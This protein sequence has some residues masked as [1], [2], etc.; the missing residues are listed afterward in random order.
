MNNI[1]Q[2]QNIDGVAI[3]G[4]AGQFPD[5]KNIDALWKNLIQSRESITFFTE[6]ELINAGVP[7]SLLKDPNYV[8]ARGI[9]ENIDL[10]DAAFFNISPREA[11]VTDP[12]HRLFLECCWEAMEDAGYNTDRYPHRV[13]VFAGESLNSYLIENVYPHFS[14]AMGIDSLQMAIGN[15]KDSLTTTVSYRMNLRGPSITIQTSSSTSLVAIAMACQ[16]L[17]NYQC[18][19]ALAG[20]VAVGAR[21]K[22]GYLYQEG[23]IV[24]RDGHCRAFDAN[25]SGFVTGSG[26]GSIVLKRLDDAIKDNDHIYA[27]IKGYAVN[28][29][30]SKKVSYSAPSVEGQAEVISEAIAFSEFEPDT[31]GYIEAHG[32]GTPMGDPIEFAALTQA[33][34]TMGAKKNNYCALGSIK[35]NIG[36]LD[37]A[38]GVAGIIKAALT[39]K[40]KKIPASLHYKNSNAHIDI[41][42]SPF[43]VNTELAD[44]NVNEFPRRAGVSSL[45]MG[46]TN[47]HIV[48]EESPSSPTKEVSAKPKLL[49]ISARSETALDTIADN[50]AKFMINMPH[51]NM[52]NVA[53]TLHVGRKEMVFRTHLVCNDA[54]HAIRLLC[55]RKYKSRFVDNSLSK[56]PVTFMFSGQGS[57]YINMAKDLYQQNEKFR[58]IVKKCSSILESLIGYK[59]EQILYP[60]TNEEKKQF[61]KIINQ[62]KFAQPAIFTVSYAVATL[63]IEMGIQP[64]YLIGHS[65]GE[66]V[67]ACIARVISLEDALK[68]I[69]GRAQLMQNMQPGAMLGVNLSSHE[70]YEVAGDRLSVAAINSPNFCVLSGLI[71]DIENIQKKLESRRTFYTRLKTSHAFHS[72]M[73]EPILNEYRELVNSITFN[74]PTLPIISNLTGLT[75]GKE[76]TSAEYWVKHLRQPVNFCAG[77]KELLRDPEMIF[78]EVGPGNTL[79]SLVE[80]QISNGETK[81]TFSSIKAP[82]NKTND[83]EFILDTAG[84]LWG[85]GFKFDD[86]AFYQKSQVSKI[87]LPTYPFERKS[88]WIKAMNE[89]NKANINGINASDSD[90][91]MSHEKPNQRLSTFQQRPRLASEYVEPV[92]STQQKIVNIISDLLGIEPVG[93]HDNF[94]DL[95]GNSLQATQLISRIQRQFGIS[96]PYQDFF[97]TPNVINISK[98]IDSLKNEESELNSILEDLDELSE[99]EVAQI[100]N[101][102]NTEK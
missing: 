85:R 81:R 14:G 87:S 29:D 8:R 38:A 94:F 95:G 39:L 83:Y 88:Y 3:I 42:N 73:T 6:E 9:L 11:E 61:E 98:Y 71:E 58:I 30:G 19:M 66:I 79:C 26:V 44:W 34:R 5:A 31:I 72:F 41:E 50:L 17:L 18:D 23:G 57:Q 7:L 100:L 64:D 20:G 37:T 82:L 77:I 10:F 93:I 80:E 101:Q 32:T 15:D 70:A 2:E 90:S 74:S 69:A 27:V 60:K 1:P 62:T 51:I 49:M 12:Q 22:T 96:L 40:N 36:H 28:N 68:L 102:F 25:S 92:N 99:E 43:Y 4:M 75:V 91:I 89:N 56:M 48:L 55:E 84:E 47:A 35:T 16:S 59:L 53:H 97:E 13:G 67:A 52:D 24:S 78:L 54:D 21:Q 33:F 63:W 65:I 86:E 76:I 46:G 45:G